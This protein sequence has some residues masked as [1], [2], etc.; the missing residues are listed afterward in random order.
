MMSRLIHEDDGQRVF[1]V[2]LETGDEAMA[3][4]EAFAREYMP[5]TQDR[6]QLYTG[7]RPIFDLHQIDE[8]IARALSD[9]VWV[10]ANFKEDQLRDMKPGAKAVIEVDTPAMVRTPLG[11]SSM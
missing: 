2:V 5:S 8:D 11:T 6:L 9:D 7:E 1:V 10:V 3:C 4:L